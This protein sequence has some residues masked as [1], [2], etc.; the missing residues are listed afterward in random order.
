MSRVLEGHDEECTLDEVKELLNNGA[1]MLSEKVRHGWIFWG[2]Q[3]EDSV[4]DGFANNISTIIQE[5]VKLVLKEIISGTMGYFL[6]QFWTPKVV[7][8]GKW[9]LTT[10]DQPFG[11]GNYALHK[12][13]CR[14]RKIC[15]EHAY[16]VGEGAKEEEVGPPGRVFRNWHPE[17]SPDLRL[18]STEEHPL[19]NLAA[20]C[21][22]RAYV[23]L[24]VLDF[25]RTQCLGVLEFLKLDYDIMGNELR[26]LEQALQKAYL[27][28]THINYMLDANLK[29]KEPPPKQIGEMLKLAVDAIPQLHL[30]Q[31][32]IPCT[33]CACE[34][35]HRQSKTGVTGIATGKSCFI[36]SLC[37]VSICEYPVA[38]YAQ[39][40]RLSSCFTICLQSKYDLNDLFIVEFFLQSHSTEDEY[41]HSTLQLL[42]HILKKKLISFK[43]A[44]EEQ[45]TELPMGLCTI[46]SMSP[47]TSRMFQ[48]V[49]VQEKEHENSRKF[50]LIGRI[51]GY[52]EYILSI[53]ALKVCLGKVGLS[54][55]KG[56]GWV[57]CCPQRE[58]LLDYLSIQEKAKLLIMMII[59]SE[60]CCSVKFLIQFWEVRRQ[61]DKPFL[62]TSDQPFALGVLNPPQTS[63]STPPKSFHIEIM[64]FNVVCETYLALPIFNLHKRECL[65]VLEWIDFEDAKKEGDHTHLIRN[66]LEVA[67]LESPKFRACSLERETQNNN[68]DWA[69]CELEEMLTEVMRISQYSFLAQVWVPCSQCTDTNKNLACMKRQLFESCPYGEDWFMCNSHKVE[70]GKGITGIL[71]SSKNKSCFFPNLCHFSI[72]EE[73]Q[74]HHAQFTRYNLCFA[75]CL[76]SSNTSNNLYVLQFFLSQ[77]SRTYEHFSSFL[78]FLLPIMKETLKSFKVASGKQLGEELVVEVISFDKN[79]EFTS[80]ELHQPD[81]LPV[82][83]EVTQYDKEQRYQHWTNQLVHDTPNGKDSGKTVPE[84]EPNDAASAELEEGVTVTA[85]KTKGERNTRSFHIR[86]EDLEL[87]FGK[88]LEDVAKELGVSRSTLKR[89]C[90]DYG[91]KRWP[92]SQNNKKNPSL[93]ETSTSNKR[94]RCSEHQVL[95]SSS[96]NLPPQILPLHN[97]HV[98]QTSGIESSQN[99]TK[100]TEDDV[101]L[102]KAKFGDDTVKVQLLVSSG[103][104]KLKEEVGKR[105]NLM[106]ASFKVYYFDEDEWILLACD[107]DLQLCI[108][109]LTASGKTSIHILV[110]SIC[111]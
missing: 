36:P 98:L 62:T 51:E 40:A 90:R 7:P 13:F 25:L 73:P 65:G 110:K 99:R 44:S 5:R 108:K 63:V 50:T 41:P 23:A 15:M 95:V 6:V 66:A 45:L 4:N 60:H 32:W 42:L 58:E 74:A 68:Q 88:R 111:Y 72:T 57:F 38:H 96:S 49:H 21:G 84:A 92:S 1:D 39:A 54:V 70:T 75:I 2:Q 43:I 16:Y 94:V 3:Q 76:Q 37:D 105:F 8:G 11:L 107:D 33:Q 101:V 86:Y 22:I 77:A 91:I 80:F 103:I 48:Y 102:I 104:G 47:G 69:L 20:C 35:Q 34:F 14:Y 89:A 26:I 24:P 78:S 100:L 31:V 81:M 106:N 53:S 30:A 85:K 67:S 61:A 56:K 109:T 28:P 12:V 55:H 93:F 27:R 79:D 59:S 64:L 19:R 82:R 17:S 83:F 71:L 46:N 9:C 18:Y 52:N 87:H 97:Q 29:C 10:S